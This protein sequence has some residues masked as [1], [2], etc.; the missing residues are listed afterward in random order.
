MKTPSDLELLRR[1]RRLGRALVLRGWR[2][3]TAESCT[4]G[5]VAKTLT[6]VA[7]SSRWVEG[8]YVVYSNAAKMRDLKVPAA[9]L[10]RHGAVSEETVLAMARGARRATGADLVIAISGIAG[11]DGGTPEKPVGTVWFGIALRQRAM[12]ARAT[13]RIFAGD[14]EAVRRQAVDFALQLLL[15]AARRS[16]P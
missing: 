8:G 2:V 1:S 13:R 11:P 3:A 10:R 5:W 4:A 15:R 9:T 6:D 14:R 7:G 12:S 16:P